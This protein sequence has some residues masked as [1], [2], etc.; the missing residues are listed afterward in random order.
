MNRAKCRLA[1]LLRSFVSFCLASVVAAFLCSAQV[2][3]ESAGVQPDREPLHPIR[4]P[5]PG[6]DL[7]RGVRGSVAGTTQVAGVDAGILIHAGGQDWR[8]FRANLLVPGAVWV[9]G[10]VFLLLGLYWLVHGTIEIPGGRSGR[11]IQRNTLNQRI[12]HWFMAVLFLFLA[13]T[14]L[15]VLFGRELFIDILGARG[16]GMLAAACKEGHNLFGPLFGFALVWVF[17][18]NMR[19]NLYERGDLHWL[20]QGG[21]FFGGHESCGEFN[22]GEKILFWLTMLF[23]LTIVGSGLVFLFPNF[24]QGRALMEQA[25]VIH[26]LVAV[27]YVGLVAGHIF[28]A[29]LGVEGTFESISTGTVDENWARAH[30]DLWY[31]EMTGDK[32]PI[33]SP[34]DENRPALGRAGEGSRV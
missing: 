32:R 2:A 15:V 11:L 25:H 26:S 27:A 29:T 31:A 20:A 8:D 19:K 17:L 10:A 28:F 5:N 21:G 6:T 30:H 23:G 22:A 13:L 16:F 12:A 14:G 9:F 4:V 33:D 34:A 24:G 18:L 1:C 3:A 7:W